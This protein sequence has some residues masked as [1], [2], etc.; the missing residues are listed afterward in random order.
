[1]WMV[2]ECDVCKCEPASLRCDACNAAICVNRTCTV[3]LTNKIEG[4]TGVMYQHLCD[5]C[6]DNVS[7]DGQTYS[8]PHLV[9]QHNDQDVSCR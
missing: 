7:I 2:R 4:S 9:I 3:I 5:K 8:G 6:S 1:M